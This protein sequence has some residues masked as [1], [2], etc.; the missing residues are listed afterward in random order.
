[1]DNNKDIFHDNTDEE[2]SDEETSDKQS[3]DEESEL[4]SD[5]DNKLDN[6]VL[7]TS[8]KLTK[9]KYQ[10]E[11]ELLCD[12]GILLVAVYFKIQKTNALLHELVIKQT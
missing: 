5:C 6:I 10:N 2:I 8:T 3:S 1:M 7:D 9:C 11:P 4:H 12:I